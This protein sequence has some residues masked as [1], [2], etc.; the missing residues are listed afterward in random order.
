M[1]IEDRVRFEEKNF[2]DLMDK[3]IDKNT[4][5]WN[6]FVDKEYDEQEENEAVVDSDKLYEEQRD[7]EQ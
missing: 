2:Y 5:L 3:F 7:Y 6:D 4:N 1:V